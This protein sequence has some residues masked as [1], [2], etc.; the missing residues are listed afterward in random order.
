MIEGFSNTIEDDEID[1][2]NDNDI[3]M[4]KMEVMSIEAEDIDLNRN[5]SLFD[6]VL[7]C[8]KRNLFCI[9]LFLMIGFSFLFSKAYQQKQKIDSSTSKFINIED[10][11]GFINFSDV[12]LLNL[13]QWRSERAKKAGSLKTLSVAPNVVVS[14]MNID[15]SNV[16]YA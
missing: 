12:Q 14:D 3:P 9:M 16:S 13:I 10:E 15:V 7:Y 2:V 6:S 1:D 11:N 4:K 5:F 8:G